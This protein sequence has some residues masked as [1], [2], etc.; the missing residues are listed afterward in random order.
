RNFMRSVV[1]TG[2]FAESC[3]LAEIHTFPPVSPGVNEGNMT[4]VV[5]L[6]GGARRLEETWQRACHLRRHRAALSR[7][8]PPFRMSFLERRGFLRDP[9]RYLGRLS[10][11]LS[12]HIPAIRAAFEGRAGVRLP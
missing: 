3:G 10:R 8:N 9:C 12:C 1:P 4:K 7:V 11:V 5:W 6:P 2:F